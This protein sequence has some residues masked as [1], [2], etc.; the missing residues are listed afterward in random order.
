M[1]RSPHQPWSD[2]ELSDLFTEYFGDKM[3]AGQLELLVA[4]V[5]ASLADHYAHRGAPAPASIQIAPAE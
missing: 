4:D 3:S 2:V 5:S 1:R